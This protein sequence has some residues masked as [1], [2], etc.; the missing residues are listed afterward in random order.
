MSPEEKLK[1]IDE[2]LYNYSQIDGAHHK[3]WCLDQI[4]RILHGDEY[5]KFVHDY[6]HLDNE[7]NPLSEDDKYEWD[8]GIAP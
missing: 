2:I 3:A 6:E 7:G 4:T 5:E 8:C 1:K